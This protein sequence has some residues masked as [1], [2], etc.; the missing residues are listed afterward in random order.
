M[1]AH[2]CNPRLRHGDWVCWIGKGRQI[3]LSLWIASST[4]RVPEEPRLQ[5]EIM[6]Q[7]TNQRTSKPNPKKIKANLKPHNPNIR[8]MACFFLSPLTL[9]TKR[10]I[11]LVSVYLCLLCAE[12]PLFDTC[13]TDGSPLTA[14]TF[15]KTKQNP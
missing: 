4:Y 2:T 3:H 13:F 10:T 6:S 9:K 12:W 5:R 14:E 1:L 11:L 7:K 8:T 15:T